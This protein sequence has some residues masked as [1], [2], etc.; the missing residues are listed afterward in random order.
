MFLD[1]DYYLLYEK[2]NIKMFIVFYATWKSILVTSGHW[3][4]LIPSG[5]GVMS[6]RR[7][8]QIQ[9]RVQLSIE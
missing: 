4:A 3:P 8:E 9:S 6:R 1:V 7:G 5:G 2:E